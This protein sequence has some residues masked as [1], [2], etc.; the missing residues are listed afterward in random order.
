MRR[1]QSSVVRL[2]AIV[3]VAGLDFALIRYQYFYN[4]PLILAILVLEYGLFRMAS[5]REERP[6]WL[7]F[8]LIGWFYVLIDYHFFSEIRYG[9]INL[10]QQKILQPVVLPL[11][12]LSPVSEP[13]A[14]SLMAAAIEIVATLFL[15][16]LGGRLANRLFHSRQ[17]ISRP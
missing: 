5:R 12:I 7:G 11:L 13:M 4:K 6:Y 17:A 9:I 16:V 3:L 15:A 10:A 2:M 14:Y 1:H 8:E